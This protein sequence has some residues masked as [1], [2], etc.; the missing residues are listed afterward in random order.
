MQYPFL[1]G[2][3]VRALTGK[4]GLLTPPA[5]TR[6]GCPLQT[7][8]SPGRTC[9]PMCLNLKIWTKVLQLM[10]KQT[11]SSAPLQATAWNSNPDS[12]D[13]TGDTQVSRVH[14]EFCTSN[15]HCSR[16]ALGQSGYKTEAWARDRLPLRLPPRAATQDT[17][18][19]H[20]LSQ[21]VTQG[22]KQL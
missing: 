1:G 11:S 6:Q 3:E 10:A 14:P 22:S 16:I 9:V 7:L 15:I 4:P 2:P 19:A 5:C 18:P 13:V 20:C 8:S 17:R 12:R 21:P